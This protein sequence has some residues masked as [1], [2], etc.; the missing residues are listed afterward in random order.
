[1]EDIKITSHPIPLDDVH[2]FYRC[3]P[4]KSLNKYYFQRAMKWWE[5]LLL[6]PVRDEFNIFYRVE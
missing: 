5:P 3:L 4:P 6:R 1:M 2:Q